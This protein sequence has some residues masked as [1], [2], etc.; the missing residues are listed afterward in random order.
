[1]KIEIRYAQ[2]KNETS[3]IIG[4]FYYGADVRPKRK[5][6]KE[7]EKLQK[8]IREIYNDYKGDY[9]EKYMETEADVF[10]CFLSDEK[11]DTDKSGE[12]IFTS[13][14]M[15]KID[16]IL[17]LDGLTR[18][19]RVDKVIMSNGKF[20]QIFEGLKE[21]E[22]DWIDICA[23]E[24][25]YYNYSDYGDIVYEANGTNVR[26]MFS[27]LDSPN[28]PEKYRYNYRIMDNCIPFCFLLEGKM[29]VSF[30]GQDYEVEFNL[31]K[32]KVMLNNLVLWLLKGTI[33]KKGE[34]EQI[35]KILEREKIERTRELSEDLNDSVTDIY[36][37]FYAGLNAREYYYLCMNPWYE[38]S[39]NNVLKCSDVKESNIEEMV[40]NGS[41]VTKENK[42]PVFQNDSQNLIEKR[43]REIGW[44]LYSYRIPS[45][46]DL[47][48]F[49]EEQ[50]DKLLEAFLVSNNPQ[51]YLKP[52]EVE[53]KFYEILHKTILIDGKLPESEVDNFISLLHGNGADV[54]FGDSGLT[55]H[56]RDIINV[57]K[58]LSKC[59]CD[60]RTAIHEVGHAV[61]DRI[62]FGNKVVKKITIVGDE[63]LN[64]AGYVDHDISSS[65]IDYDYSTIEKRIY[66]SLAGK[67][68]EE[69]FFIAS[70]IGWQQ[71]LID[72]KAFMIKNIIRYATYACVEGRVYICLPQMEAIPADGILNV[73]MEKYLEKTRELLKDKKDLIFEIAG[74]IML[75]KEMDGVR[76]DEVYELFEE[77]QLVKKDRELCEKIHFALEVSMQYNEDD[78]SKA[79]IELFKQPG[80]VVVFDRLHEDYPGVNMNCD[81]IRMTEVMLGYQLFDKEYK[82]SGESIAQIASKVC[83]EQGILGAIVDKT[84]KKFAV[85]IDGSD[86]TGHGSMIQKQ[87]KF[88]YE[89]IGTDTD[90]IYAGDNY[91]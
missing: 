48:M 41:L 42:E 27:Y 36:G 43:L 33:Q 90:L 68:A 14:P 79:Y 24:Y 37:L 72:V 26:F 10:Q 5:I 12:I 15:K 7:K 34:D 83:K 77:K 4:D 66:V 2:M 9:L 31:K 63:T 65:N 78:E 86:R 51:E 32:Q 40:I 53:Q 67:V 61:V 17:I 23:K 52:Q 49:S 45:N 58:Q 50:S 6:K 84:G 69:M 38:Y 39:C 56:V 91:L 28:V 73:L 54:P 88:T 60:Y 64:I 82:E 16:P 62:L 22:N 76:F 85:F 57:N 1:M 47:K 25:H 71:D 30:Y 55:I 46:S 80:N 44:R 11:S 21:D 8:T 35:N 59:F 18:R 20:T 70:G 29:K 75:E 19:M 89:T 13:D 87:G 81:A 3:K 74:K